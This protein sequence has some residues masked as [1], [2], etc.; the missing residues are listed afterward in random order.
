MYAIFV[1]FLTSQ[2]F[3]DSLKF[4]SPLNKFSIFVTFVT[5]HLPIG[6]LFK[7]WGKFS[8]LFI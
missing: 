6:L 3:N 7:S 2:S 1:T 8:L 4:D 5:S